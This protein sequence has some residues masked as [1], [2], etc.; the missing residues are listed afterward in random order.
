[1]REYSS[2]RLSSSAPAAQRRLLVRVPEERLP[3]LKA[4]VALRLVQQVNCRRGW[5]ADLLVG[6]GYHGFG[7]FSLGGDS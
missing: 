3:A 4:L 1:M 7:L 6:L 5:R 2:F